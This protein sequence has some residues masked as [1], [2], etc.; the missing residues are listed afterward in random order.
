VSEDADI[1]RFEP[2]RRSGHSV[3]EPL[4]RAVDTRHSPLYGFPREC[5]CATY[6]DLL[7]LSQRVVASTLS[8][9]RLRNA[10]MAR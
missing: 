8:G 5:P 9:I 10:T 3:D 4:V 2:H 7:S 1:V 6:W